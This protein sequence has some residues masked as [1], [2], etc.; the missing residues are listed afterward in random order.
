MPEVDE[1]CTF[2]TGADQVRLTTQT[3]GD[4]ILIQGLHLAQAEATSLAWLVNAD[5]AG[6]LKFEVSFVP[7]PEPEPEPE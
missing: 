4:T 3:N 6:T 7:A 5:D 2:T 1:E